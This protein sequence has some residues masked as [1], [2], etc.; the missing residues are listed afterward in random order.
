M[1]TQPIISHADILESM[2]LFAGKSDKTV[3]K[4]KKNCFLMYESNFKIFNR[5]FNVAALSKLSV[6]KNH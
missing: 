4:R 3:S 6:M 5:K 2:G 1:V